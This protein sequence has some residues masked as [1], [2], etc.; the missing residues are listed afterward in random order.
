MDTVPSVKQR[1]SLAVVAFLVVFVVGYAS[2]A[3]IN[4]HPTW[5]LAD[6]IS[7]GIAAAVVVYGYE[8]Q[9]SRMLAEKVRVIR[10][11]NAFVRNELQVLYATLNAPEKAR[12]PAVERSVERIDWALRELLPGGQAGEISST[13]GK[14][15]EDSGSSQRSA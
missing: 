15:N 10:D 8:R 6:E 14:A 2:D 5:R 13:S 1:I 4:R 9:R 7:L 12:V 3:M 11:M